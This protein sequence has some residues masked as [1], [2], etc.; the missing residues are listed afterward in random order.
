MPIVE[1]HPVYTDSS[2]FTIAGYHPNI[3]EVSF[4]RGRVVVSGAL[5]ANDGKPDEPF[6]V[7]FR[8]DADLTLVAHALG[9]KIEAGADVTDVYFE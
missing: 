9:R 1:V 8:P 2:W 3:S 7:S 4:Q 6:K 5:F